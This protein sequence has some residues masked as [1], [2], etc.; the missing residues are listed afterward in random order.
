MASSKANSSSQI[1]K[2]HP[3]VIASASDHYTRISVNGGNISGSSAVVG[4]LFGNVQDQ[5]FAIFDATDVLIDGNNQIS[6]SEIAKKTQLWTAVYPTYSLLGWYSFASTVSPYHLSLH[7][8]MTKSIQKHT[9]IFIL[10]DEQQPSRPQ[11]GSSSSQAPAQYD[12]NMDR[13]PLTVY[14]FEGD[15]GAF[16]EKRFVIESTEVERL[17]LDEITSI[18]PYLPVGNNTVSPSA[19][20][21]LLKS[22]S[23]SVY[24]LEQKV[25]KVLTVLADMSAGRKPINV[26]LVRSA[27]KILASLSALDT[28]DFNL[29]LSEEAN[30]EMLLVCISSVMKGFA[31][32]Q[33]NNELTRL[34]AHSDEQRHHK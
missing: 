6:E 3:L 20:E 8:T 24:L 21:V 16:V 29:V 30:N 23:T 5:S 13:I 11:T 34:V 19:Y 2:I 28:K 9:P 14:L 4:L 22:L 31:N 15:Q 33:T 32:L 7:R 10:F 18:I 25:A 27:A 17:A 1:V 26:K 12:T